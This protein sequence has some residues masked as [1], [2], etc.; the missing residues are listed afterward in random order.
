MSYDKLLG[1]GLKVGQAIR[2]RG[3]EQVNG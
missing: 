2:T 1:N 3:L